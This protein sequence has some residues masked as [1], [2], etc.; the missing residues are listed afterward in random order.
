MD[1]SEWQP[2]KWH[3]VRSADKLENSY[4]VLPH[5]RRSSSSV[6]EQRRHARPCWPDR[7]SGTIPTTAHDGYVTTWKWSRTHSNRTESNL[8]PHSHHRLEVWRR[9]RTET[10]HCMVMSCG[11]LVF[12]LRWYA[13]VVDLLS[14]SLLAESNLYKHFKVNQGFSVCNVEWVFSHWTDHCLTSCPFWS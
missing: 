14:V 1:S 13:D 7:P 2:L 6:T 8:M 5:S 12:T 11:V 9:G 4:L 10:A 3:S